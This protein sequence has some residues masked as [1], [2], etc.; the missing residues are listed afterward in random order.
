MQ[1]DCIHAL[2]IGAQQAKHHAVLHSDCSPTLHWDFM[3]CC[4]STAEPCCVLFCPVPCCAIL[5]HAV[6]C[7]ATPYCAV[8]CCDVPC[9]AMHTALLTRQ[10]LRLRKLTCQHHD[11]RWSTAAYPSYEM[12]SR[13]A[14]M[15]KGGSP[16]LLAGTVMLC[17]SAYDISLDLLFKSHSLHGAIT[18][19]SGCRP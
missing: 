8:L 3:L 2:V 10:S 17:C 9:H 4:K 19:M 12:C 11:L 18:L 6:L 15:L 14:S 16:R 13:L 7:C 1:G 5:C